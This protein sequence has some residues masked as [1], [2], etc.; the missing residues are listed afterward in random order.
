VPATLAVVF[1]ADNRASRVRLAVVSVDAL[2][3]CGSNDR[4]MVGSGIDHGV[5]SR[6]P[7]LITRAVQMEG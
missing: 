7:T 1:S 4:T 2:Y 6:R 5:M 3:C